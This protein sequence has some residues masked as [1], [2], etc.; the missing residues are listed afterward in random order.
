MNKSSSR[1]HIAFLL[2]VSTKEVEVNGIGVIPQQVV[3]GADR[4]PPSE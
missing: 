1:S 2:A 3:I 4:A